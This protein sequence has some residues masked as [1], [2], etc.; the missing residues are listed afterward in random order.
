MQIRET[1]MVAISTRS[2]MPSETRDG[3]GGCFIQ[4]MV[5]VFELILCFQKWS[6]VLLSLLVAVK[7]QSKQQET[8]IRQSWRP[9][10]RTEIGPLVRLI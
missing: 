3:F 6:P 4:G 8:A 1:V 10:W 7:E 5:Y 9:Y 2:I